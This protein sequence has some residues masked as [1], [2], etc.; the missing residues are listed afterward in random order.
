MGNIKIVNIKN[1]VILGGTYIH[2]DTL[3]I[4]YLI[5]ACVIE[6]D[7]YAKLTDLHPKFWKDKKC[8]FSQLPLD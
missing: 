3:K 1:D 8:G 6:G 2:K 4:R 5:A 7:D